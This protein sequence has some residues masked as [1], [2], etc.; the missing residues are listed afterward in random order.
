MQARRPHLLR[1][2]TPR[3]LLA[4]SLALL[5]VLAGFS[6]HARLGVDRKL[7][8]ALAEI[9]NNPRQ[10]WLQFRPALEYSNLLTLGRVARARA[11]FLDSLLRITLGQL[12]PQFSPIPPSAYYLIQQA[13]NTLVQYEEQTGEDTSAQRAVLIDAARASAGRIFRDQSLETWQHLLGLFDY[14]HANHLIPPGTFEDYE[15]WSQE[16][17]RMPTRELAIR[18]G[19]NIAI[20]HHTSALGRLGMTHYLAAD[21]PP[22]VA[23]HPGLTDEQV[24]QADQLFSAGY[25]AMRQLLSHYDDGLGDASPMLEMQARLLYNLAALRLSLL[26]ERGEVGRRLGSGF[27]AQGYINSSLRRIPPAEDMYLGFLEQTRELF[28]G[29]PDL[30]GVRQLLQDL[31]RR[32]GET[33]QRRAW[34]MLTEWNIAL[35]DRMLTAAEADRPFLHP[36]SPPVADPAAPPELIQMLGALR[37]DPR[38]LILIQTPRMTSGPMGE[39]TTDRFAL[40]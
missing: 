9:P 8:L 33:G 3:R 13:I 19:L 30:H 10:A 16:I 28:A 24:T 22:A 15:Q 35:C 4:L 21:G 29:G 2:L 37:L 14:L 36:P 34:L 17:R 23:V 18:E 27:I 39:T 12:N 11:Q 25:S 6:L 32:H 40:R 5:V 20:H 7:A 1:P 31:I 26:L 38:P